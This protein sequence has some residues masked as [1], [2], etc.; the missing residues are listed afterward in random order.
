MT[1]SEAEVQLQVYEENQHRFSHESL[2]DSRVILNFHRIFGEP[3]SPNYDVYLVA[4]TQGN[5]L[6]YIGTL[7]FFSVAPKSPENS[8]GANLKIKIES[9]V[10]EMLGNEAQSHQSITLL[11]KP[12]DVTDTP[13]SVDI[14]FIFLCYVPKG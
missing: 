3:Y 9:P 12:Q 6:E 1:G 8:E 10:R 13:V 5:S 4:G 11:L 7:S 14:E 2:L